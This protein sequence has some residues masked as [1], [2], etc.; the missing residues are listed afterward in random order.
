MHD[1]IQTLALALLAGASLTGALAHADDDNKWKTTPS[2]FEGSVSAGAIGSSVDH[3]SP[4]FGG[5]AS[6]RLESG[7]AGLETNEDCNDGEVFL[8]LL[9]LHPPRRRCYSYDKAV[10]HD[11]N[12]DLSLGYDNGFVGN[13]H[14]DVAF[15]AFDTK[16]NNKQTF[17]IVDLGFTA[18]DM[19]RMRL[20]YG[21]PELGLRVGADRPGARRHLSLLGS[22][23]GYS[24]RVHGHDG[25]FMASGILRGELN[26]APK[27]LLRGE[28]RAGVLAAG[29]GDAVIS[30]DT[31]SQTQGNTTTTTTTQ[32]LAS[33]GYVQKGVGGYEGVMCAVEIGLP[34]NIY[35]Q[36]NLMSE[37]QQIKTVATGLNGPGGPVHNDNSTTVGGGV[38]LGAHF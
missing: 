13:L 29:K 38:A 17:P 18:F 31:S 21:A 1:R 5:K 2:V 22:I 9:F 11:F 7:R 25:F 30:V 24:D 36:M 35:A 14:G 37:W 6:L 16:K 34:R 19:D 3:G 26:V 20:I 23:G 28:A 27:V 10:F 8:G 33:P 12:M 4:T 15:Y 32:S